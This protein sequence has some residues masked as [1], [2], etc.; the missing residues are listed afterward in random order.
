MREGRRQGHE[1]PF[2]SLGRLLAGDRAAPGVDW[3]GVL[4]LARRHGVSPILFWRLRQ[5]GEDA[6][7]SVPAEVREVLRADFFGAAARRMVVE[8]QLAPV[9]AA[10]EEAGVPILVVKGPAAGAFYPHP[11]MRTY[12][13]LD[14]LVPEDRLGAAEVAGIEGFTED[15]GL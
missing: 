7:D 2:L 4:A 14:V 5:R 13:D 9:L 11:A 8:R 3:P 6:Q 12:G 1:S 10:I 15:N